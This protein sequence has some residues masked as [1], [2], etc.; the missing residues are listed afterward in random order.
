MISA[1]RGPSAIAVDAR[2]LAG[3]DERRGLAP[4]VAHRVASVSGD[5]QGLTSA[6]R[7]L[8]DRLVA[9]LDDRPFRP[10]ADQLAWVWGGE[11]VRGEARAS[12]VSIAAGRYAALLADHV[13]EDVT[14]EGAPGAYARIWRCAR[15]AFIE[16]TI[17]ET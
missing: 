2:G 8:A 13:V 14:A 1:G 9:G 5:V 12:R 7:L 11:L 15:S 10:T 16:S 3:P 4:V 6:S 17:A